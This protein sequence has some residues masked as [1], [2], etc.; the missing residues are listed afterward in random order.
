[1]AAPTAVSRFESLLAAHGGP[2]ERARW[3]GLR[4]ALRVVPDA[5][6]ADL[7]RVAGLQGLQPHHAAVLG[8]AERERA[9]T[10]TANARLL[11]LAAAQGVRLPAH[12]HRSH[13][14]TGL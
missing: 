13:Y 14:L 6:P 9:L 7:G 3:A 1:V 12:V 2:R 4:A 5:P 8:V 11:A 10:L